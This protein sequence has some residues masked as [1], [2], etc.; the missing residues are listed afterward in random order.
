M[1]YDIQ[2]RYIVETEMNILKRICIHELQIVSKI[3]TIQKAIYLLNTHRNQC[4]L[5]LTTDKEKMLLII[6]F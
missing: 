4:D 6:S 5:S 1:N 2:N 3:D